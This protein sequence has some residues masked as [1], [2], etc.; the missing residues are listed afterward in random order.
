MLTRAGRLGKCYVRSILAFHLRRGSK[1]PIAPSMRSFFL[2]LLLFSSTASGEIPDQ[3]SGELREILCEEHP[4][5]QRPS[6][7]SDQYDAYRKLVASGS[8]GWQE[9]FDLHF[10]LRQGSVV[11]HIGSFWESAG[12]P[13]EIV[14][15]F[16]AAMKEAEQ[17]RLSGD[18]RWALLYAEKVITDAARPGKSDPKGLSKMFALLSADL[19]APQK[20]LMKVAT[21]RVR[22]ASRNDFP[23]HHYP[24]TGPPEQQKKTIQEM[25]EWWSE[26]GPEIE[27]HDQ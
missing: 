24:W 5:S 2:A 11:R 21:L 23:G 4:G 20:S 27:P 15:Q 25:L 13:G 10:D 17:Q 7:S 6:P 18:E 12:I 19:V 3:D 8:R 22:L 26:K 9:I 1:K 16:L 14:E